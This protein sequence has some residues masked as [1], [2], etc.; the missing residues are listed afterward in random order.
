MRIRT[1]VAAVVLTGITAIVG[2]GTAQA[3][4]FGGQESAS[5]VAFGDSDHGHGEFFLVGDADRAFGFAG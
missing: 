3:D 4:A 2:A 1:V 5:V